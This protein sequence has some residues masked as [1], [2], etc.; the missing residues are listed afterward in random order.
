[1]DKQIVGLSGEYFVAAELLKR[2]FQVSVTLGNAKSIDLFALN[3]VTQKTNKIGVKTLRQ[4]P[5]CFTLFASKI[6]PDTIYFFVYLNDKEK[7][8][9]YFIVTGKELMENKKHF[10][11]ASLVKSRE[12]V[13]HGPLQEHKN[14]WNKLQ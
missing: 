7:Q 12:T 3:Q 13:N 2:N 5:N 11:G 8:A 14:K 1:M 4:Q 10:Y 6:E 9:D